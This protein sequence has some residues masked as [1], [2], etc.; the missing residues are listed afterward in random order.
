[1]SQPTP[2]M[3]LKPNQLRLILE[4][5][6]SGQLQ[7]AAQA[8]GMT[9]PAASR[10]LAETERQLGAELFSRQPKGLVPTEIG[11]SVV[12]RARVIIR[13]MGSVALE[14]QTLRDG[15]GGSIHIGAVTGPAVQHLVTAV[16]DIKEEAPSASITVDVLPSRDLLTH[17]IA[18]E[19]DFVLARILPEFNSQDFNI[20]PLQDEKVALMARADHP[21]ARAPIVTLSELQ[22][23]EWI[24]QPR[25]SPISEAS[26]LAFA[27]FGLTEPANIVF[28]SSTLFTLAYIAQ[29]EAIAPLSQEV[30]DFLAEPPM[31]VGFKPLP[32]ANEIR[33][34]RYYL[35]SLRRRPLSPLAQ[36]LKDK[37]LNQRIGDAQRL[38]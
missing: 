32:I 17:L 11:A 24:M 15:L 38:I 30:A 21:L 23:Q 4:I 37:L 7:M 12:K 29:S 27:S 20:I 9:Q 8:I 10:M 5:A 36:R 1:M 28:S 18:G 16:R 35:L 31:Q 25:I 26:L 33:V 22:T 13:E 14:L 19:M 3:M 2:R 6:E 34:A